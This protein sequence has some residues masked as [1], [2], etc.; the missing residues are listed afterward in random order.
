MR[1]SS[2]LLNKRNAIMVDRLTEEGIDEKLSKLWIQLVGSGKVL[3]EL[4]IQC[5]KILPGLFK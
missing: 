5:G 3:P 2:F 1:M 4:W